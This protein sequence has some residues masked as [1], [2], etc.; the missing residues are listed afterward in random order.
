MVIR[1]AKSKKHGVFLK[2]FFSRGFIVKIAVAVAAIFILSAILAPVITKH[3]PNQ[4]NLDNALLDPSP[5][6]LLGCDAYGRDVFTRLL[7]G[8]RVS[9]L[10]SIFSTLLA[11]CAGMLLGLVAGYYEGIIGTIILRYVDVQ[12]SIPPLLFTLVIG[13]IVG[14]GLGGMIAAI[15]FSMLPG[16]IR[17]MNGIVLSIKRNDYVVALQ[18]ANIKRYKIILKHLLP[19]SLPSMF[20][21]FAM[22]LGFAIM[23]EATLSF[24]GIGIQPPMASWGS[25]VADGYIYLLSE[26]LLA[27][28]PGLCITLT[29]VAFNI[30]G[31]SLRDAI[32][33]RLRG[34]L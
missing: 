1:S 29:V 19:N 10:S 8:A 11:A 18:V 30:I 16:F 3:D 7:Y 22:N 12:L 26:P 34:K 25:M 17:L 9:L 28:M 27:F 14:K 15:S 4:I 33:P 2:T 32:D 24:L 6:H 20:I 13:L 31:D 21:M 5:E 23:L